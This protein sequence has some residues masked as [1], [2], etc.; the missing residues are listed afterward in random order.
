MT[1]KGKPTPIRQLSTIC[2]SPG[3]PVATI[4]FCLCILSTRPEVRIQYPVLSEYMIV[5]CDR[6]Q[7]EGRLQHL[8]IKA[9]CGCK[10][11]SR[12]TLPE[13]G[14]Q[15]Y[16]CVTQQDSYLCL[17]FLVCKMRTIT[18]SAL[19][20]LRQLCKFL[21]KKPSERARMCGMPD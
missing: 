21:C 4:A 1:P 10:V 6:T 11:L 14:P 12:P 7:K 16:S 3:L 18:E 13:F 19:K 20:L 9:H 17:S 8:Q 2:S 5:H 15:V